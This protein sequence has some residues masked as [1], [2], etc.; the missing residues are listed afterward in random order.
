MTETTRRH[1]AVKQIYVTYKSGVEERRLICG[2]LA[3]ADQRA[4]ARS[5][6]FPELL[7]QRRE[8]R[9]RQRG[10]GA[11]E[12][13]QNIAFE[14]LPDYAREVHRPRGHCKR[15]DSLNDRLS[16]GAALL[17]TKFRRSG[18]TRVGPSSP[19]ALRQ[20]TQAW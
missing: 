7:T 1:V 10:D 3:A 12:A 18:N 4:P 2:R 9:S 13:V 20:N 19:L 11:A 14:Q 15:G 17:L 8:G 6:V 16:H 5:P